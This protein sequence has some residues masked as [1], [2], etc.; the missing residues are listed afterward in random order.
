MTRRQR[1]ALGFG[2]AVL[3]IGLGN[4]TASAQSYNTPD[5]GLTVD[6]PDLTFAPGQQ[7]TVSGSGFGPFSLVSVYFHSDPILLGTLTAD[8][9]GTVRGTFDVPAGATSAAH[10]IEVNGNDPSGAPKVLVLPVTVTTSGAPPG[11]LAFTGST[12]FGLVGTGLLLGSLG[13]LTLRLSRRRNG[14]AY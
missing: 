2:L 9:V 1:V 8:S 10:T 11:A 12:V 7:F 6:E 14:K 4:F 3:A 5:S 13:F